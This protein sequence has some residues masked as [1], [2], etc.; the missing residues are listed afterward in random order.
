MRGGVKGFDRAV[1]V[2]V[3]LQTLLTSAVNS[4]LYVNSY[5]GATAGTNA[6]NHQELHLSPLS[7]PYI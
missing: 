3:V 1:A 4:F 2:I 6:S 5:L 7:S